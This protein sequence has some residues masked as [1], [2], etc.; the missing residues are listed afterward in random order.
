MERDT[1]FDVPEKRPGSIYRSEGGE[2]KII[3]FADLP[4]WSIKKFWFRNFNP[5]QI[6]DQ[7]LF[8][9]IHTQYLN[10]TLWKNIRRHVLEIHNY[11]CQGC[12]SC[13]AEE[14]HHMTYERWLQEHHTDL[15]ALC[16]HCHNN[17]HEQLPQ[18]FF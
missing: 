15:I 7:K 13:Q 16:N 8:F 10:S 5:E 9:E 3:R 12:Y 6:I 18:F 11:Q 14:V 2:R 4:A 17:I 1:R